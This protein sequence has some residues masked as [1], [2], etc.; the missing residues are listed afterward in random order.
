MELLLTFG[1]GG[2]DAQQITAGHL[3]ELCLELLVELDGQSIGLLACLFVFPIGIAADLTQC[4]QSTDHSTADFTGTAAAAK[5]AGHLHG[6]FLCEACSFGQLQ[7]GRL[8]TVAAHLHIFMSVQLFHNDL[9]SA[10]YLCN[11]LNRTIST[12]PLHFAKVKG[13]RIA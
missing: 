5:G 6:F 3:A 12:I 11:V 8:G 2:I 1:G 13:N 10:I 4:Q 7:Q 9:L